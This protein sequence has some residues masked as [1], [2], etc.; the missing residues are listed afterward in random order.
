MTAAPGNGWPVSESQAAWLHQ[1][2]NDGLFT[3]MRGPNGETVVG[4]VPA[5][6][7][8]KT[9]SNSSLNEPRIDRGG[10][11]IGL[12]LTPGNK[13][14]VWDWQTDTTPWSTTGDP[15]IPFG[16]NASLRRR[17]VDVDWNMNWPSEF[18]MLTSDVPNS[19]VHLGGPA[20]G[21]LIHGNGNWIQHPANLDDQW[22]LFLAYDS[23]YPTGS[24]WLAPGGM[25]LVTP[26]GQRRLLGHPYNTTSN[27]R[28]LSFAKFSP[29][30][31]YVLFTSDMNGSGR[32]D[33]FLAELPVKGGPDTTPPTVS[34]SAPANGATVSGAAVTVSA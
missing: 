28:Y 6:G 4:Y 24:S 12:T 13:L 14:V 29:D 30:G 3:W 16:H 22:A 11:Y 20:P 10:R 17:W 34:F 33:V 23:L 18:T 1:S 7:T 2:E 27:Y 5:T 31:K 8:L 19:G 32:S 15:G 25:I 26:N 9:I 21:T